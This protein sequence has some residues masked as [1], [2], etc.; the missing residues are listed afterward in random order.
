MSVT[1]DTGNPLEVLTTDRHG[2]RI[3]GGVPLTGQVA[4][5]GAKNAVTKQ[6]VASM[7]SAGPTTL[8]NV[9]R[10]A[11]VELVRGMLAHLGVQAE[12]TGEHT[13]RLETVSITDSGLA[14]R[15]TGA[16]RIPILMMGPLLHRAGEATIPLPGGCQI[17]TRPI[18]FHLDALRQMGAEIIEHPKA[19]QVKTTGLTGAHITLPFPSVGATENILLAAVLARG[20]TV[21][22]GAAVEPEII[23]TILM[24]QKMGA[25]I[26]VETDRTIVI[27]GVDR[28]SGTRHAAIPDRIEAASFAAAAVATGGRV[29]VIGA[30]QTD[31]ATFIN[32]LL[33]VG[34]GFEET[35]DGLVFYQATELRPMHVRTDVHPGLMTD[36]QQPLVLLLTQASGASVVHE[37]VY[38][39]RFGYTEQLNAMGAHISLSTECLV[40]EACRFRN[41]DHRHSAVVMGRT[42]LRGSR[43]EIPDLRAGF[44]YVM[45]ALVAEGVSEIIGTRFV[46]RGYEDPVGKLSAM[47]AKVETY[48]LV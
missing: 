36:W 35:P 47:G 12:W 8:H 46:E 41:R 31:L 3:T 10:I 34:G 38:E 14:E 2:Y 43:L 9:P 37:T 23:D 4:V 7:L 11:E 48:R 26:A 13:V 5:S 30:R 18:D 32:H 16:N 22:R 6:M 17:G 33:R 42:T 24:L 29:E 40:G 1:A 45:A 15:Y 21:I 44:A 20:T 27:E 39:D 28:L 19:V 25:L